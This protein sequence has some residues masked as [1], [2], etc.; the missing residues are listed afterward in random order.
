MLEINPL[1]VDFYQQSRLYLIRSY[2]EI[3]YYKLHY[4]EPIEIDFFS[5]ID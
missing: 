1:R 2:V 3:D 5:Q 4:N